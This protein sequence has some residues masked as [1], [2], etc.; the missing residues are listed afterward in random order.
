MKDIV[1]LLTAILFLHAC[2]TYASEYKQQCCK[3]SA[4]GLPHAKFYGIVEEI[5]N[6]GM[7]G[8]W[9]VN[10]RNL[11]VTKNSKVKEKYG[12]A[13][14]GSYVK[15]EGCLAGRTFT[16]YEMEVQE[17]KRDKQ[18]RALNYNCK[19]LGIVESMPK[20]GY[21]GIWI[22]DGRQ[23]RVSTTTLIDETV[24][25]ASSGCRASIKG[26]RTGNAVRAIEIVV[27]QLS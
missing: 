25:K 7:A 19:F 8:I 22:V 13:Q 27:I 4:D 3:L 15:V 14:V 11:I 20:N 9:K 17:S 18:Q 6:G 5:P 21:E 23:V 10:G 16:V 2:D 12:A 24:G 26:V 1:F